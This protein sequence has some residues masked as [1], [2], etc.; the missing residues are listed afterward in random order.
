MTTVC[1]LFPALFGTVSLIFYKWGFQSSK[2]SSSKFCEV[3][4]PYQHSRVWATLTWFTVKAEHAG[5]QHLIYSSVPACPGL[6]GPYNKRG[7][8]QSSFPENVLLKVSLLGK[9]SLANIY[10][11]FD[12]KQGSKC[13]VWTG[14]R[15]PWVISMCVI[16]RRQ[17]TAMIYFWFLAKC[18]HFYSSF[19]L[20]NSV[21]FLVL[22]NRWFSFLFA[23][24]QG[25]FFSHCGKQAQLQSHPICL[26]VVMTNHVGSS[27]VAETSPSCRHLHLWG[28]KSHSYLWTYIRT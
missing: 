8:W 19:G 13:A 24:D 27:A 17:D 7:W 12:Q 9:Y 10:S 21:S 1:Q 6:A 28:Y 25:S 5:S 4:S 26:P 22:R 3:R 23:L 15:T 2:N 20:E 16:S 14:Q 11:T 18:A